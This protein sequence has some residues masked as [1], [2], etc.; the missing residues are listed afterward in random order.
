MLQVAQV[1]V[2]T[3]HK[4]SMGRAYSVLKVKLV[5]A[6]RNQKVK[7]GTGFGTC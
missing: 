1:V 6:S 7:A 2:Y 3:T 5:D 4:Y